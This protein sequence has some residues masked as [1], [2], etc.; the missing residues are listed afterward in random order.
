MKASRCLLPKLAAIFYHTMCLHA[1]FMCLCGHV[2]MLTLF[3]YLTN[4]VT[5]HTKPWWEAQH[6][7]FQ[8]I[9]SFM[10][11]AGPQIARWA[12]QQQMGTK[13]GAYPNR[14][15]CKHNIWRQHSPVWAHTLLDQA[16]LTVPPAVRSP[17]VNT[18]TRAVQKYAR[19]SSTQS[20]LSLVDPL[21][22]G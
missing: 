3:L 18:Y 16:N 14:T 20:A 12:R 19:Q 13:M 22:H 11:R 7:K 9:A 8:A 10:R 6:P 21:P 4:G 17:Q 2:F 15:V 5:S 1:S